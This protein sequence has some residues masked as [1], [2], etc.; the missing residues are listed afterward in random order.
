MLAVERFCC[1]RGREKADI[2]GQWKG[3]NEGDEKIGGVG[4]G[5]KKS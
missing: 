4:I 1:A 3:R 5:G 2:R